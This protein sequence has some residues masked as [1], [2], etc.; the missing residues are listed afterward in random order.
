MNGLE[1]GDKIK[2]LLSGEEL[3]FI[4]K[5]GDYLRCFDSDGKV[6][7]IPSERFVR[8]DE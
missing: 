4:K 7:W 5:E 1:Y 8:M 3:K 2:D 6:V